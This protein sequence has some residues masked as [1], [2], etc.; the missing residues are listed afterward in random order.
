MNKHSIG[1]GCLALSAALALT[2]TSCTD[3]DDHYDANTSILDTQN[4][5]LWENI[6]RNQDLSQFAALLKKTEFDEVLGASQTYTVWAPVNGSF[7]Y[8][9][10]SAA[11]NDK[12]LKEFVQNHV[13]R[14]NYT[15]SGSVDERVFMLSN[16]VKGVYFLSNYGQLIVCAYSPEDIVELEEDLAASPLRHFLILTGKYELL[17]PVLFEFINSDYTDFQSFISPV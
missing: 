8:D 6:E 11:A 10:L 5:T 3:W 7:D 13:A 2:L 14:N 17:D 12:V 1:A 9:A 15:V 4:A 16:D